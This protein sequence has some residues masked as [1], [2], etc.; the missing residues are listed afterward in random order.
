MA[1]DND[2][3]KTIQLKNSEPQRQRQ[4]RRRRRQCFGH[5]RR[6]QCPK[7]SFQL[8]RY[9]VSAI[10][11]HCIDDSGSFLF[12]I[13][14]KGFRTKTWEPLTNL[15]R[16]KLS[17]KKYIERIRSTADDQ[18][19]IDDLAFKIFQSQKTLKGRKKLKH[20]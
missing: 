19:Q 20:F 6:R 5:R 1:T 12:L 18:K 15:D 13:D 9:E 3:T 7:K 2:D 4:R 14:W 17:L 10:L 11:D 8:N 16:C